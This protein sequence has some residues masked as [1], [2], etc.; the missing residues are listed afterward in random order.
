MNFKPFLPLFSLVAASTLALVPQSQVPQIAAQEA[1]PE[2][3]GSITN[4]WWREGAIFTKFSDVA[5]YPGHSPSQ[6]TAVYLLRDADSLYVGFRLDDR[7]PDGI[8]AN[9]ATGDE[10]GKDDW[11]GVAVETGPESSSAVCFLT[12]PSGIKAVKSVSASG[13]RSPHNDVPWTVVARRGASGWT[14][15]A[16]IPFASIGLDPKAEQT[17]G[18]QFLRHISRTKEEIQGPSSSISIAAYKKVTLL[19]PQKTR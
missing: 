18:V 13:T 17:V 7:Q 4:P 10:I 2:L 15:E 12:N 5:P 14:A 3:K 19:P 9:A 1:T 16:K 8:E 6:R 11:A